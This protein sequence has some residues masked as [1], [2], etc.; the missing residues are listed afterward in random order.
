[1]RAI[2]AKKFFPKLNPIKHLTIILNN[3]TSIVILA[4][5]K[6]LGTFIV[7]NY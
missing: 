2:C 3:T 4:R 5:Y 6:T 1:M 7:V